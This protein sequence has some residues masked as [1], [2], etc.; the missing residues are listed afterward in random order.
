[1]QPTNDLGEKLWQTQHPLTLSSKP[2]KP[3]RQKISKTK[4][5]NPNK[6]QKVKP[7]L[8]NEN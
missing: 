4:K 6:V 2:L 1:M 7:Y 5:K 3:V 8:V